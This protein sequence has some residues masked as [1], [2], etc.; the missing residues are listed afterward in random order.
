MKHQIF[1]RKMSALALAAVLLLSC[2]APR[3]LGN[4]F[5]TRTPTATPTFT[6]SPTPTFTPTITPSPTPTPP[7]D[8]TGAVLTLDDLP[9]GFEV[10]TT[11]QFNFSPQSLS[12]SG[13]KYE[14]VFGFIDA[15]D[16]EV[17]MGTNTLLLSLQERT[18]F[19]TMLDHPEIMQAL[20]VASLGS[21]NVKEQGALTGLENIGD[22]AIG[23][24]VI[25]DMKGIPLHIDVVFIKRGVVGS[26]LYVFYIDGGVPKAQIID[27]ARKWDLK[28]MQVL[29]NQ[30]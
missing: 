12:G 24:K 4:L 15:D 22:Q 1:Y 23:F 6:P 19:N 9:A 5:A 18:V 20:I 28:T 8:I 3:S 2:S 10:L 11:D 29:A 26:Q 17:V 16:F 21:E 30:D 14:A 25:L 13:M 27:L 7:P